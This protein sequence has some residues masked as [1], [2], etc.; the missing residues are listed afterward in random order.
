[1]FVV[2]TPF[3]LFDFER[4]IGEIFLEQDLWSVRSL[5]FDS[6][7]SFTGFKKSEIHYS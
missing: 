6:R 5:S 1:M 4:F 3:N 7:Q 2:W